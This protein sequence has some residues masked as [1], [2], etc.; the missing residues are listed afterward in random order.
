MKHPVLKYFR[1][2]SAFT[3]VEVLL[4]SVILAFASFGL[5][6]L[7]KI[8]DQMAYR[9]RVEGAIASLLDTRGDLLVSSP[10]SRLV[11]LASTNTPVSGNTYVFQKGLWN[12][13]NSSGVFPF[14]LPGESGVSTTNFLTYGKPLPGATGPRGLCPY[15]ELVTLAFNAAPV[16]A[17]QVDV[18]Y[19]VVW[20]DPMAATNKNFTFNFLKHDPAAH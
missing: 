5:V 15:V 20:V 2:L 1:N 7:L 6:G 3:L 10:F 16:S 9:A 19:D 12:G 4:A 18:T 8:S 11:D 14:L 13:A 17:S